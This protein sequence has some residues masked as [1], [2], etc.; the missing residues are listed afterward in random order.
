MFTN[1]TII[2]VEQ[3]EREVEVIEHL[4]TA[5]KRPVKEKRVTECPSLYNVFRI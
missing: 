1:A 4:L 5:K 3:P 2:H